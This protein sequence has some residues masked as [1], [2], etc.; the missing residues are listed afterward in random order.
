MLLPN[1]IHVSRLYQLMQGTFHVPMKSKWEESKEEQLGISN[2]IFCVCNF[3]KAL[4]RRIKL[5]F[6]HVGFLTHKI[7]AAIALV[8]VV[9]RHM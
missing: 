4:T 7:F 8:L 6:K 1:N 2:F 9:I 3:R 5:F